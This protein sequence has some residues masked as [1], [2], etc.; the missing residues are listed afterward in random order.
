M[1]WISIRPLLH[2]TASNTSARLVVDIS[3]LELMSSTALSLVEAHNISHQLHKQSLQRGPPGRL[4]NRRAFGR[5]RN[6][7]NRE[8]VMSAQEGVSAVSTIWGDLASGACAGTSVAGLLFPINTLKTRLMTGKSFKDPSTYHNLWYCF[9][10]AC[11]HW[12]L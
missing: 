1:Q 9:P 7:A 5:G 6:V 4:L 3:G 8:V 12:F 11:E 10:N 2:R